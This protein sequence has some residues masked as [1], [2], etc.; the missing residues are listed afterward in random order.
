MLR[1]FTTVMIASTLSTLGL[2]AQNYSAQQPIGA[3]AQQRPAYLAQ[4]G[5][6]QRLGAELPLN[7]IYTDESGT[8]GQLKQWMH[9]RPLVLAEV[10]YRCVILCPTVLHDLAAGLK[11]ISLVPGTDY[12]VLI[13]SIDP[14]DRPGD[15]A[16]EKNTF[17][18]E[19]GFNTDGANAVHFLTAQQISI[20]AITQATGFH[21]V[22][23]PG[24][25]GKMDQ[26]AHATVILFATPEGHI[27]KY[28]TGLSYPPADLRLAIFDASRKHI[29]N[30][31]DLILLYCC[32]YSPSTGRYT[33][34]VLRVVSV[35]GL[36]SLLAMVGMFFFLWRRPAHPAKG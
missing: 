29:S 2:Y 11:Q 7:A 1:W 27:S 25:D 33:L 14:M 8:T 34:S 22:R 18:Q 26:F 24:P 17:V 21:Y 4:A 28:L 3:S 13:F 32:N 16:S 5:I 6:E 30:P 35:A 19:A 12:D 23:I 20:E 9:G 10:Y 36:A 15:A 31:V